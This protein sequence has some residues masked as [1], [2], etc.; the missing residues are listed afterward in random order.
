M[1]V[2]DT[3]TLLEKGMHARHCSHTQN[4]LSSCLP[5]LILQA[6]SIVQD[7]RTFLRSPA[8]F[9]IQF[10]HIH[11]GLR[12]LLVYFPLSSHINETPWS[13][14]QDETI[15]FYSFLGIVSGCIYSSRLS[16][17]KKCMHSDPPRMW[18]CD[19]LASSTKP[20]PALLLWNISAP[21]NQSRKCDLDKKYC[22]PSS[23][24]E[25]QEPDLEMCTHQ[26]PL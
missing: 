14:F 11:F 22:P 23:T 16:L 25:H 5:Q 2:S 20:F 8:I 4:T 3:H 7:S 24:P 15:N 21:E 1:Q 12:V 17:R 13:V 10:F 18:K 26:E 19:R 9:P 6:K